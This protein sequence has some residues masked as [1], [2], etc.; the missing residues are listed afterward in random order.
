MTPPRF[1]S[2]S[3]SL[4]SLATALLGPGYS[5][6]AAL[7]GDEHW[8]NQFGPVGV[9]EV[10]QSVIAQGSKVYVGGQ[11]TGA[12]NTRANGIA[13]YDGT[14]W[15]PLNNGVSGE[16]NFTYV[17]ALA[18][19]A[20]YVY[21]GGNF[22]NADNSGARSIARWDG[23]NWSKMGDELNGYVFAL[24]VVGT[25]VYAG[26]IFVPTTNTYACVARWTG[27]RWVMIGGEFDGGFPV[28]YALETDGTN[29][30]VG[31]TFT[32]AGGTAVNNLAAWNG[33]SWSAPGGGIGS[34]VVRALLYQSGRLYVGGSFTNTSGPSFTNLAVWDGSSLGAWVP[35][36]RSVRDIISDGTNIYVGG[37]FTSLAGQSVARIARFDGA[38]WF[39]LSAG[40]QGFGVA[41][42]PGIYKMCLGSDGHLYVA[43][44][45][46][47]I[48]GVGASH[49]AVWDGVAWA[50]MG[51]SKSKGLTHFIGTVSSSLAR[52]TDLFVGGLFTEAGDKVVNSIGRWDGTN[53]STLGSGLTGTFTTGVA[54]TARALAIVGSDL[55]AGGNFTNAG[56][57][58]AK[59][60]AR[61]NGT[62]WFNIGNADATVRALAYD[63]SMLF[64]GGNFTNIGGINSPGLAL[65][66]PGGGWLSLGTLA[67]GSRTVAALARDGTDV[68]LGGNFTSIN[69]VGL[70]N[71]AHWNGS[72]W[73][74]LGNGM[75][76]TVNALI[77]SNGVVYAGGTFALADGVSVNRV[78]R[79]NGSSWSALGGGVQGSTASTTISSFLLRG[80]DLY[81]TGTF[82]NAGGIYTLGLAKW[83]GTTWSAPFGSGLV[84]SP[85]TANATTL[86]L[87]GNDLYVGGQF[88]FAGDKPS[89]FFGRWNEQKNF[90]PPPNPRLVNPRWANGQFGFRVTG[91]SGE[92]YV[93]ESA[94]NFG[95]WSP[96]LTNSMPLF[97][98][99]DASASNAPGS[100]YRA[101]LQ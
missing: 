16:F 97:D 53:W 22:T 76:N 62:S 20:N 59:G 98:F 50:G 90:Y 37:E 46:N 69:G 89:M 68:Y 13:G 88:A 3:A 43:G 35:A 34:G 28:A 45:F 6:R 66:V 31:G 61:W 5:S 99:T 82:T 63:G 60:I 4:I 96:R 100:V 1:L 56:G 26:G 27:A 44:N 57:V 79:W 95:T 48:G 42:S 32:S 51:G 24:K 74:P 12:G 71:I 101:V 41:A 67:G 39:P 72:S 94:T 36:N 23:A 15:F 9:N 10:A 21:A 55:Y 92:R 75:N 73:L 14:N 93:I 70:T 64:V 52:G 54:P 7:P 77:A 18:S 91:L 47:S 80:G 78:A 84:A 33:S 65:H 81:V 85:G 87:I 8:D 25:N 29:L 83:D 30:F 86:A 40:V 17:W 38:N 58:A 2:A 19:D 11:L 49:A